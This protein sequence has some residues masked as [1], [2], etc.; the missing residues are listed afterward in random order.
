MLAAPI[1][2]CSSLRYV[3]RNAQDSHGQ[4]ST[5]LKLSK[6]TLIFQSPLQ[7][8]LLRV[9]SM[10]AGMHDTMVTACSACV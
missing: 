3:L 9:F 10:G 7:L 6:C 2:T 8:S 4:L 5:C 1:T